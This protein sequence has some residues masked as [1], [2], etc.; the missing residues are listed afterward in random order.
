MIIGTGVN[1]SLSYSYFCYID[2]WIIIEIWD[3]KLIVQTG[4]GIRCLTI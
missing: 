1:W 2:E 4:I 3:L